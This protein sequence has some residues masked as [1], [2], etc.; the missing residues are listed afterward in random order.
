MIPSEM[1]HQSGPLPSNVGHGPK[2]PWYSGLVTLSSSF[3]FTPGPFLWIHLADRD[4]PLDSAKNY[5][6][7]RDDH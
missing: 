5:K 6:N 7:A 2:P 1:G 4:P 3:Q